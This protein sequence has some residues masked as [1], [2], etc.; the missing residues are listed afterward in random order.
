MRR[1]IKANPDAREPIDPRSVVKRLR[2]ML[3]RLGETEEDVNLAAYELTGEVDAKRAPDSTKE[4]IVEDHKNMDLYELLHTKKKFGGSK[5]KKF[6]IAP[7]K[8]REI[9]KK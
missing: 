1:W 9:P 8:L 7:S 3:H 4:L 2:S 5:Q 6:D